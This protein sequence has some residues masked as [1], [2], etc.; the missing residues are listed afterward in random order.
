MKR[1]HRNL[2]SASAEDFT[3]VHVPEFRY[4]AVDGR[5]DPNTADA[6]AEA[7]EA[8][9]AV[10][11]TVKFDS[12]KALDRDAVVGPLEGLWWA[13]DMST[14][15]SRDKASWQWRMMIPQPPWITGEMIDAAKNSVAKKM[16]AEKKDL[17]A[18]P[19][20]HPFELTEGRCL[21]IL[22]IGTYDDEAPT[23]EK[24]HHRVLPERGLTFNGQHHE[25]YLSDAR[26]TAPEKLKTILRQPV[27][28][29]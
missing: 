14:F 24:L 13:D 18:L 10:S 11:Y 9:Y 4:L 16:A 27:T 28:D 20:L 7:V 17:P 26:R 1:E 2:Y 21:Q 8:L 19:L 29:S 23:L 22:H 15:T 3:E 6:Y 12:K 5:G 25:I